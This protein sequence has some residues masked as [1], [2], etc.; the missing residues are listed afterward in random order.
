MRQDNRK[1]F[2]P[3]A[4][5]DCLS[6]LLFW[7]LRKL[8]W[9]GWK[10]ELKEEDIYPVLYSDHS[11]VLGLKLEQNWY[12]HLRECAKKNSMP[13]FRWCVFRTFGPKFLLSGM[14]GLVEECI[15][16]ILQVVS[17]GFLIEYF[18]EEGHKTT[19]RTTAIMACGTTSFIKNLSPA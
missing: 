10:R 9:T 3:R 13:S 5:A 19:T 8:L 15:F 16:R 14:F 6:I 7:W 12:K 4:Q 11:S 2:P 18:T 17:L 1:L